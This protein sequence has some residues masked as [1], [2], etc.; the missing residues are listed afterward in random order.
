M[1]TK[2]WGLNEGLGFDPLVANPFRIDNELVLFKANPRDSFLVPEPVPNTPDPPPELRAF[3][4]AA[5]RI[6]EPF[7]RSVEAVDAK[8]RK[9]WE[10]LKEMA[11]RNKACLPDYWKDVGTAMHDMVARTEDKTERAAAKNT[12]NDLFKNEAE[13]L[14]KLSEWDKERRKYPYDWEALSRLQNQLNSQL[15]SYLYKLKQIES[16][17]TELET[18]VDVGKMTFSA[19]GFE[20]GRQGEE[21]TYSTAIEIYYGSASEAVAESLVVNTAQNHTLN[22]LLDGQALEKFWNQELSLPISVASSSSSTGTRWKKEV[23][24]PMV[25]KLSAW[26]DA[27]TGKQL[28]YGKLI[29]A[30]RDVLQESLAQRLSLDNLMI[31]SIPDYLR[32]KGRDVLSLLSDGLVN[33]LDKLRDG[34]DLEQRQSLDAV[35]NEV[36]TLREDTITERL[37][38]KAADQGLS[39]F[40]SQWKDAILDDIKDNVTDGKELKGSLETAFNEGLGGLLDKWG[41][42]MKKVPKH[43]A[44][45][46]HE[47]TWNIRFAVRRYRMTVNKILAA[48]PSEKHRLLTSLDALQVAVSNRLHQAYVDGYYLF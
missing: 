2:G 36:K 20:L 38:K 7:N 21:L 3:T 29:G 6:Q 4:E 39:K 23:I 41:A 18:A 10:G 8:L 13:F 40:W 35:L 42:E 22:R 16:K 12:L 11:G 45:A 34:A 28:D 31:P 37:A 5:T 48:Q 43:S 19:L 24:E 1:K 26:I 33:K 15:S 14:T 44:E 17:S 27:T 9:T 25:E 30:T 32:D 47:A 46:L